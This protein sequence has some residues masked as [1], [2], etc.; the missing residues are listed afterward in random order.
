MDNIS[1]SIYN[2]VREI[3]PCIIVETLINIIESNINPKYNL[4]LDKYKFSLL[5]PVS[6]FIEKLM[7]INQE[8]YPSK[9]V[10]FSCF[11]AFTCN[12]FNIMTRVSK[13]ETFK[14]IYFDSPI[15]PLSHF[16]I[17]FSSLVYLNKQLVSL[18]NEGFKNSAFDPLY[19]SSNTY[20]VEDEQGIVN[21][22]NSELI[23]DSQY[24][25]LAFI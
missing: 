12:Y 18:Y 17:Q 4:T 15:T 9:A 5:T 16:V 7:F 1:D 10:I 20:E 3:I 25:N 21:N 19:K 24:N 8:N 13:P 6:Y 11:S 23:N 22:Y 14:D 2:Y